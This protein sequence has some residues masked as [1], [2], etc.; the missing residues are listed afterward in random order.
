MRNKYID[1]FFKYIVNTI[2]I[3]VLFTLAC[4]SLDKEQEAME[5]LDKELQ[6]D[7]I[8]IIETNDTSEQMIQLKKEIDAITNQILTTNVNIKLANRCRQ[9]TKRAQKTAN[10]LTE[11]GRRHD[12][13]QL[14]TPHDTAAGDA[15]ATR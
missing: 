11:R 1:N 5:A 14:C 10:A 13:V 3:A 9:I 8:S 12:I 7:P 4:V 15:G 6:E 2:I